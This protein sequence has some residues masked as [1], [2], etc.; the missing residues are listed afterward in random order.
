MSQS[1]SLR[2]TVACL[3]IVLATL[4][5]G[6]SASDSPDESSNSALR[7]VIRPYAIQKGATI[8]IVAPASS[9]SESYVERAVA[10]LQDRGYRVKLSLGYKNRQAYLAS[11]DATRAAEVNG[12]FADSEIDAILCLRGGYGSPRILDRLDYD[13]IRQNTKPFIGYSDITALLNAIYERSGVVTFHGPMAKEFGIGKGLTQYTE[14]Y[15]WSAFDPKSSLFQ[16]WGGV[17]PRGRGHRITLVG[18]SAEGV[19]VGGNLSVLVSTIGTPYEVSGDGQLLFLEDVSEKAFRIDRMLNQLRLSG[20]LAK[21]RGILLGA[22]TNCGQDLNAAGK[23][24]ED[25]FLEYFGELGV[26]VLSGFPAGHVS[27]QA[28]LPIGGQIRLDADQKK[29]TIL[30]APVVPRPER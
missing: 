25:L 15:F 16:D 23:T 28:V 10:N 11:P 30:E 24:L 27:D 5:A 17:G 18:G 29:V 4:H 13:L 22:F 20:K 19:L 14:R 3:V 9:L 1:R 26:P 6:D 7:T 2:V 8:G 21:F 12:F